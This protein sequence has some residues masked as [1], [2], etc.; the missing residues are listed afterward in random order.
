M[1]GLWCLCKNVTPLGAYLLTCDDFLLFIIEVNPLYILPL[2]FCIDMVICSQNIR[3]FLKICCQLSNA[4][5]N[6]DKHQ[7]DFHPLT[8]EC[9]PWL[10]W[11][12]FALITWNVYIFWTP[13]DLTGCFYPSNLL[14]LFLFAFILALLLSPINIVCYTC[15]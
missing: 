4:W 7:W 3:M 15:K 2:G 6:C 12:F 5:M 11:C 13:P 14:F 9:K 8:Q 1:K 10:A